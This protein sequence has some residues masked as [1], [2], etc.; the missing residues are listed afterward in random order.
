MDPPPVRCSRCT[1]S[2]R[3]DPNQVAVHNSGAG[4]GRAEVPEQLSP[5]KPL[6][7]NAYQ[8]RYM[9]GSS[10]QG[11]HHRRSPSRTAS[12]RSTA[13]SPSR[14]S[15]SHRRPPTRSRTI[16]GTACGG[17]MV[18]VFYRSC[19]IP[20]AQMAI[21]LGPE[22]WSP[23]PRRGASARRLPDRSARRRR[24]AASAR[25]TTSP[26][27]CRCWPSAASGRASDLMVPLHMAMVASTVANG[28]QMMKPYVVDATLASTTARCST[29]D[30]AVGVE[31]AHLA[32][33]RPRR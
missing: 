30:A 10:L 28:G 1:A 33:P 12:R 4:R 16:G 9:P 14:P 18:E 6:L 7:A 8:E 20:F 21:E 22:R 27:T 5:G 13:C 31:A 32:A 11:R 19:N 29:A 17:T 25:S 24:P 15:S 3:F 23:A 26:T 2:R